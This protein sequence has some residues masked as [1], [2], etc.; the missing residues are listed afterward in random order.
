MR[1]DP[2]DA[3]SRNSLGATLAAQGRL[4]E[5]LPQLTEA[6]RLEPHFADARRNLGIALLQS[7]QTNAAQAY[8]AEPAASK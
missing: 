1:L 8:L 4:A 7:G 2:R 5:A 3:R 6:V